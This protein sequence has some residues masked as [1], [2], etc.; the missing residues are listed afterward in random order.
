MKGKKLKKLLPVSLGVSFPFSSFSTLLSMILRF[1]FFDR[2]RN[3][4]KLPASPSVYILSATQYFSFSF[5]FRFLNCH[6]DVNVFHVCLINFT[7]FGHTFNKGVKERVLF[8]TV[9]PLKI[10][11]FNLYGSGVSSPFISCSH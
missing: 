10:T 1:G 8:I 11:W 4:I 6:F 5:H 2:Y 7:I 9:I 3:R